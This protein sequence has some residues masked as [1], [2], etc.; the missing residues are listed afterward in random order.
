MIP[1]VG[2]YTD[3][4]K[5]LA[6]NLWHLGSAVT[7]PAALY[8]GLSTGDPLRSGAPA[9]LTGGVGGTSPGYARVAAAG[10]FVGNPSGPYAASSPGTPATAVSA[11][12]AVAVGTYYL[13]ET[14]YGPGE[15][16]ASAESTFATTPGSQTVTVYSPTGPTSSWRAYVGTT[17]GGPYFLAGT[18]AIGANLVLTSTPPASG[19]Q[20]PWPAAEQQGGLVLNSAPIT[21]PANSGTSPWPSAR[22]V[23]LADAAIGGNIL[24]HARLTPD[25]NGPFGQTC[26][27]GQAITF[28]AGALAIQQ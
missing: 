10:L 13:V 1:I 3:Y 23:F 18:P 19:Q 15:S 16:T 14:C 7:P 9:E 24:W 28:A 2:W 20:P 11:G 4:A 21:F 6:N 22:S 27:P 17:S 8:L 26:Q 5:D 25:V 12:G